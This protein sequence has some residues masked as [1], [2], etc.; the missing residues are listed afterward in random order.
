MVEEL[1]P[2]LYLSEED[3]MSLGLTMKDI[4][5]VME[6]E[7]KAINVGDFEIIHDTQDPKRFY[8]GSMR[9]IL[10]P[11]KMG[12]NKFMTI[13]GSEHHKIGIQTQQH[14]LICVDRETVMPM[15]ALRWLWVTGM[16]TGGMTGLGAKYLARKDIDNVVC[17]IG[18]GFQGGFHVRAINEAVKVKEVRVFDIISD[19]AR[20]TA[21]GVAKKTGLNVNSVNSVEEG[22]KDA[23]IIVGASSAEE[24]M[25]MQRWTRKVSFLCN[26]A[27]AQHFEDNLVLSAD[28]KCVD[29]RGN[30]EHY[31]TQDIG[32]L[33]KRE[34]M[35]PEDIYADLGE[36]LME[37]KKGRESAEE[38]NLFNHAGMVTH[39][40]AIAKVVLELAKKK[41]VGTWCRSKRAPY[42]WE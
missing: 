35:S 41:G 31:T 26:F 16:R 7:F 15:A 29:W 9:G 28:K 34:L 20:A 33:L 40:I 2:M 19:A 36:L 13:S 4:M 12:G 25:V 32:S 3:V 14:L 8:F 38:L 5:N 17:V 10:G 21:Q 37:H 23:D 22:I 30:Y 42:S 27:S 6:E 24:P 1:P 39:D 18:A 11:T